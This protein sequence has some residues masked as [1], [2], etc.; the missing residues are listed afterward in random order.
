MTI[1]NKLSIDDEESFGGEGF[2]DCE[3][4]PCEQV[5]ICE[6]SLNFYECKI[7]DLELQKNPRI[8]KKSKLQQVVSIFLFPLYLLGILAYG[9]VA[10]FRFLADGGLFGLMIVGWTISGIYHF[11]FVFIPYILSFLL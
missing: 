7:C 2:P 9:V 6:H 4:Y 10:F 8:K 3:E 11:F 1:P 5:I